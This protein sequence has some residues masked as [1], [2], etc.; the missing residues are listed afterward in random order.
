[1]QRYCFL[2][3]IQILSD[4]FF[5]FSISNQ[6]YNASTN[7]TA[8]YVLLQNISVYNNAKLTVDD[9][10]GSTTKSELFFKLILYQMIK[11]I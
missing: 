8:C 7:I 10:Q 1:M 6:L 11:T 3:K 5:I 2:L 9:L 4:N